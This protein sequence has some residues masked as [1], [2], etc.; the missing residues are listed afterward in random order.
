MKGFQGARA[1]FSVVQATPS[2][3]IDA[4]RG[5]RKMHQQRDHDVLVQSVQIGQQENGIPEIRR[6]I[7]AREVEKEGS[8]NND[9]TIETTTTRNN[10]KNKDNKGSNNDD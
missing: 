1:S 3:G 4:F 10:D 6:N 8:S 9:S 7:C 5:D 2:V